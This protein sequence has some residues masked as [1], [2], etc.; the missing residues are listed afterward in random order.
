M[1]ASVACAQ[2]ARD[3][4]IVKVEAE[5]RPEHNPALRHRPPVATAEALHLNTEALQTEYDGTMYRGRCRSPLNKNGTLGPK[6]K[7][8]N[9]L[10]CCC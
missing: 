1:V 8:T 7:D 4:T 3:C 6:L 10:Q 9:Q 2:L 5:S